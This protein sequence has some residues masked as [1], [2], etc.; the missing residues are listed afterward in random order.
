M[1]QCKGA[2]VSETIG[3][4]IRTVRG[5]RGVAEIAEALGVNRKT[6]TRW[7]ADEA[8]PDGKSLLALKEQFGADPAW[9]LTGSGVAQTGGTLSADEEVLL[10]GYRALDPATKKRM[11][12]F[13]L[14]GETPATAQK[15]IN[16]SATGGQAAGGDIV[17]KGERFVFS[18]REKN[19]KGHSG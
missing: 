18:G 14:G 2:F 5:G 17:N 7:E 9:I 15:Q 6:I 16:V 3:Q 10:N 12:A 4:R 13:I 1:S 8:L 19:D 11:L